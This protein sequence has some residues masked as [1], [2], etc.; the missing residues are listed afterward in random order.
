MPYSR[1]SSYN[2][3]LKRTFLSSLRAILK[4]AFSLYISNSA[5]KGSL[6]KI[7]W[8]FNGNF[9]FLVQKTDQTQ[10]F[11]GSNTRSAIFENLVA[12]S[13]VIVFCE[14]SVII[15]FIAF[16]KIYE[17]WYWQRWKLN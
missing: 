11:R 2:L 13:D 3:L 14:C 7:S 8:T 1:P 15:A 12:Q 16:G 17:T 4:N 5:I 6:I 10:N 9:F